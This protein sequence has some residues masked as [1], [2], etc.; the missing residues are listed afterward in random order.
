M[1]DS[2]DFDV[3]FRSDLQS[4]PSTVLREHAYIRESGAALVPTHLETQAT[5]QSSPAGRCIS[6]ALTYVCVYVCVYIYRCICSTCMY[7]YIFL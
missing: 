5:A 4:H 6:E 1:F 3:A 7:I 2:M